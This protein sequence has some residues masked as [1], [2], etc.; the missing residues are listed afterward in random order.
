MRWIGRARQVNAGIE[1]AQ[2]R[3]TARA[4]EAKAVWRTAMNLLASVQRVR[5]EELLWQES[6]YD[7]DSRLGRELLFLMSNHE[8][9]RATSEIIDFTRSDTL[10]TTIKI[11]VDLSQ[12]THEAFWKRTGPI[13]LPIAVLPPFTANSRYEPDLFAT[14]TDAA[15][16]PVPMLP[17]ADLRHQISAAMAEIIAKMAVAHWPATEEGQPAN[18]S[19]ERQAEASPGATRDERLLLSAAIYRMLRDGSTENSDT[20]EP[21]G[22]EMQRTKNA[23]ERLLHLLRLYVLPLNPEAHVTPANKEAAA[24]QQSRSELARR[25]VKVLQALSESIIMVVLA[26]YVTAPSVLTVRVPT[27]TLKVSKSSS[28]KPWTWV[29]R[30]AGRL[31]IDVLL[32]TADADRQIQI[33]LPVGVSIDKPRVVFGKLRGE[34]PR[35][36]ISVLAPLPLRDLDAAMKQVFGAQ[37]KKQPWPD[38]MVQS[39]VDLAKVK[40]ALARDTLRHY[41]VS[42][43]NIDEV[44]KS[45]EYHG[46]VRTPYQALSDLAADLNQSDKD[47]SARLQEAW[48]RFAIDQ[49]SV[50]RRVV[51]D[52]LTS[53]TLA[54]RANVIEDPSHRATPEHATVYV[55]VT[56][57]DLDYF[58][59]ARSSAFM[60]LILMVSVLSFL[61]GWHLVNP[62]AS[63]PTTEVLAIVLTLF[64]TIQ[65]DRIERPDR[66]TLRGRLFAIGSWLVAGSV[67]PSLTLA[68]ALGFQSQGRAAYLWASGCIAAQ[69]CL[70]LLMRRGPLTPTGWPRLGKRRVISTDR[71]SYR[72]F[73]ALRSAYWRNT[74]A[75]A[76]MIGRLAYG[77]VVWQQ[78]NPK[79]ETDS[80]SPNAR[81]LLKW[82][83]EPPSAET[84]S[85]L[86]LLRS[87]T[88]R[89]AVTFV[90]F[91]DKPPKEWPANV[92]DRRGTADAKEIYNRKGVALDPGRLAPADSV[93]STVDVFVGVY[94]HELLTI[95]EHPLAIIIKAA[96]DKLIVLDAQL[97]VPAP[98]RTYDDRQWSRVRVALRDS[99][100]IHRLTGFLN[101]ICR[102]MAKPAN[103]RHMVA[104]QTD[105]AARLL[106][107]AGSTIADRARVLDAGHEIPVLTSDLDIVTGPELVDESP[108]DRTWSVLAICVDA[109]SNIEYDIIDTLASIRENF[110]LAGLTYALLHGT[111][112]MILYVHE[113]RA[114]QQYPVGEVMPTEHDEAKAL[115]NALRMKPSCAGLRVPIYKRLS[116][117]DLEPAANHAYPMLRVRFRWQDRPGA[118]LNVLNSTNRALI[119]QMPSIRKKDWSVSY[120]RIQVLTGQVAE[121]RLTIRLHIPAQLIKDWNADKMEK[122]G[123]RIEFL[124]AADAAKSAASGPA[125][126]GADKP[127]EPLVVIDRIKKTKG[128]SEYPVLTELPAVEGD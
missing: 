101:E 35:L 86:A 84:S 14:V 52:T 50:S 92:G 9:A 56:V 5:S 8:W 55:D 13:W 99:G 51:V 76:L 34:R 126:E 116:R 2:A 40:L 100:D 54:A 61:V 72:H 71:P 106:V 70:L 26:D 43:R 109:R 78:A 15:G 17:A 113:P 58:S 114:D 105:P 64:A 30:P 110:Q 80:I 124:A 96:K 21:A 42:Y 18:H 44:P 39:I 29:I 33:N 47:F 121:G 57:D 112:V 93:T 38:S 88:L 1:H 73:E 48:Q 79:K 67:L 59:T 82:G 25:A 90:V 12:V 16:D 20:V 115:E 6:H 69:L 87:S 62:K 128:A 83:N 45:S 119:E 102:A 103:A 104:V 74:T 108:K 97:P 68:V 11:D 107:V 89:Q 27:R 19:D 120:A 10:E 127:E 7:H 85:V 91:R 123:R 122:M 31:E 22:I 75:E 3:A 125:A 60:S 36:D 81:P 23:R 28:I 46:P 111:A 117:E 118:T 24:E 95:K 32:P 37:K 77:Y 94:R 41:K 4:D 65:A 66:S 63:G 49:L 98:V 53:Q